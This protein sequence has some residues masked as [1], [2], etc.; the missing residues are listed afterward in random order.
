MYLRSPL[1]NNGQWSHCKEAQYDD[2]VLYGNDFLV[3]KYRCAVKVPAGWLQKGTKPLA[4]CVKEDYPWYVER[5]TVR[6][7]S[8]SLTEVPRAN[9]QI[10]IVHGAQH[11]I[12]ETPRAPPQI[13]RPRIQA[14]QSERRRSSSTSPPPSRHGS[15][16]NRGRTTQRASSSGISFS[17]MFGSRRAKSNSPTRPLLCDYGR[18][19][20]G[21]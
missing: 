3:W 11:G 20:S 15:Q 9:P 6:G 16:N 17:G 1:Y 7:A 21:N 19:R 12:Q 10:R 18:Y 8:H 4:S 13:E 5:T 14:Q 2:Y